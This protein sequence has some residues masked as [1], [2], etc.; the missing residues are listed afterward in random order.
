MDQWNGIE[1]PEMYP[2]N[3]LTQYFNRHFFKEDIQV[4]NKYKGRCA[5]SLVIRKMQIKITMK[6]LLTFTGVIKI[7]KQ[8]ENH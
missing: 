5:T 8:S 7:L 1:S 3:R 4:S 2:Y 6:Y